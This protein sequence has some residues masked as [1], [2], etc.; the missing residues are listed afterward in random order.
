[1]V[2]TDGDD[3]VKADDADLVATAAEKQAGNLVDDSPPPDLSPS[4]PLP[5]WRLP[6][7]LPFSSANQLV[8]IH[9]LVMSEGKGGPLLQASDDDGVKGDLSLG[10]MTAGLAVT[11]A[12]EAIVDWDWSTAS[13]PP[14]LAPTTPLPWWCLPRWHGWHVSQAPRGRGH[15]G[16]AEVVAAAAEVEVGPYHPRR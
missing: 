13:P 16:E 7:P 8:L 12:G 2:P 4:T 9:S 14:A 3:A 6:L 15:S 5:W 11:D 1:M 10:V